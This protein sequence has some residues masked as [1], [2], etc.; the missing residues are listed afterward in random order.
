[1]ASSQ[2][3][4]AWSNSDIVSLCKD[5]PHF[6]GSLHGNRL[7]RVSKKLVVKF[8]IG[9]R[10]QEAANQAYARTHVDS[11][12]LYIPQ[13]FRYFEDA[14]FGFNMGFI[15][16]EYVSGVGLHT[17]DVRNHPSIAKRNHPSIA[18]IAAVR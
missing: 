14:S 17:L 13:V 6:A 12:V 15:V 1:M 2:H 7:T 18:N 16:M 10:L 5:T 8:G 9:V 4:L 11:T 3:L